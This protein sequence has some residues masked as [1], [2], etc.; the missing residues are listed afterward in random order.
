MLGTV[1]LRLRD[2]LPENARKA[3][4]EAAAEA[5]ENAAQQRLTL[6]NVAAAAEP[7]PPQPQPDA[8]QRQGPRSGL[9]YAAQNQKD[10]SED[11]RRSQ[12]WAGVGVASDDAAVLVSHMYS[13]YRYFIA[14]LRS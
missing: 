4:A 6:A 14:S 12:I 13:A 10:V 11:A 8:A 9:Q 7:E 1:S 3:A 2:Y 5:N